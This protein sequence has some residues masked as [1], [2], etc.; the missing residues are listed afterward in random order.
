M[1]TLSYSPG[2]CA[3]LIHCPLEEL[4]VPFELKRVDLKARKHHGNEMPGIR[5][6][7]ERMTARPA[8]KRAME[9]EGIKAFGTT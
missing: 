5:P 2:A 3:L 7:Y 8:V 9:R 6:F 1:Y 4:D